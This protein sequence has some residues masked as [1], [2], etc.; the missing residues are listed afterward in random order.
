MAELLL[1]ALILRYGI[2]AAVEAVVAGLAAAGR[3]VLASVAGQVATTWQSRTSPVKASGWRKSPVARTLVAAVEVVAVAT[4]AGYKALDR[5][6]REGIPWWHDTLAKGWHDG[7]ER[8]RAA[9][10]KR[11]EARADKSAQ[12]AVDVTT[13]MPSREELGADPEP[14]SSAHPDAPTPTDASG[15]PESEETQQTKESTMPEGT[16]QS[17]NGS[18]GG[19]G[20][21]GEG[22]NMESLRAALRKIVTAADQINTLVD[23]LLGSATAHDVGAATLA[24]IAAIF[25]AT[26]QLKN[27]A[28]TAAVN[29]DRRHGNLEEATNTADHAA[30]R[31]F[32]KN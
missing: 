13:V 1:L 15:S 16:Q 4:K 23:Q 9:Y 25:N 30:K 26:D 2:P 22:Y 21:S 11:L 6:S 17:Q 32:Y 14:S 28:R 10:Q 19:G 27:A 18:S 8:G 29:L 5:L 31:E 7:A 12:K 20:A 3:S 24:D